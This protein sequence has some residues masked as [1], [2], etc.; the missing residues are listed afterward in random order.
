MGRHIKVIDMLTD[1]T[2][3][4]LP[5]HQK[6]QG[7][8]G[9][10]LAGTRRG[11]WFRLAFGPDRRGLVWRISLIF[12]RLATPVSTSIL[13]L[14]EDDGVGAFVALGVDQRAPEPCAFPSLSR[15]LARGFDI[16][17]ALA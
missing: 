2:Q 10:P 9:S 15:V 13:R 11:F 8:A 12:S 17:H 5:Q 7:A 6:Q 4:P 1:G 3:G 16:S 14:P